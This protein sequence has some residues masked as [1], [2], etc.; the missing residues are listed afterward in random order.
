[1]PRNAGRNDIVIIS[2]EK[3]KIVKN[4]SAPGALEIQK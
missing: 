4:C 1:M 2:G 3:K